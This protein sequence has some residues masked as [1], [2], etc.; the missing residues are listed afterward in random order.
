MIIPND[1]VKINNKNKAAD[2]KFTFRRHDTVGAEAAEEDS[3]FLE[4]CFTDIGDLSALID[5]E[6]PKRIILGRT[7]VGKTALIDQLAKEREVIRISPESLSFNYL[8]NSS[9][10]QFFLEAGVKLDLFFKLLWRH[11]LPSN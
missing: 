1:R 11:V 8:T 5:C 6:S 7:G 2:D 4:A 10:L 9:T 3:L